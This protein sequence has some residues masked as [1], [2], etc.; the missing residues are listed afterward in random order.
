MSFKKED[1]LLK[2]EDPEEEYRRR[3]DEEKT[4]I[5]WGQR[6]LFLTFLSF[7]SE[8]LDG[9]ISKPVIVYA[10]AAPG[11]NIGLIKNLFPD[12]VIHGYDPA[13][14]K[15]KTEPSRNLY[16][17]RK[18]FTNKIAKYWADYQKRNGNVY[19][20]SDIRTADYTK[21]KNLGENETQILKDMQI[22]KKWVEIIQ[23]VKCF[24]KFRLPY[25]IPGL[26]QEIE[27][28]DGKIYKQAWAPQT[29]TETRLVCSPPYSNKVY[30]C[31]KYQSQMFYH[32]LFREKKEFEEGFCDGEELINDYDSSCEIFI[33]KKYLIF[34]G[35]EI[36]KERI[37]ELSKDTTRLLTKGRK[38]K[39]T[40]SYLRKNPRAIKERNQNDHL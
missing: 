39:D 36:K 18:K 40:L 14:F 28:L 37:L 2:E 31:E 38:Y 17:Y 12:T 3:K 23:P 11:V 29:S 1:E 33:W 26:P 34:Q 21:A 32:N 30:N 27:Y 22:Q 7:L 8:H 5:S 20:I 6:K 19:F 15:I 13:P 24:L 16:V 35:E 9:N 4:S 25:I 10:G